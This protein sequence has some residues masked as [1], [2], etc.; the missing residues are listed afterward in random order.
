[1]HESPSLSLSV[2]EARIL[3]ALMEKEKTTPAAYP[4]T[5]NALTT[6]CNQKSARIPIMNLDEGQVA[7]TLRELSNRGLIRIGGLGRAERYSQML[8]RELNINAAQQAVL[9]VLLLR[10]PQ[11]PNEIRISSNRQIEFAE[12]AEVITVLQQLIDH[13]L[14]LVQLIGRAPGQRE[15]RYAQL[16]TGP[17][18]EEQMAQLAATPRTSRLDL[19]EQRLCELEEKVKQ[20]LNT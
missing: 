7:H 18:Q 1:M 2:V 4:L 11:T 14:G 19:L 6:A 17:I 12:P 13:E 3:G 15:D 5:V 10:G 8:S 16:L 9:C 20:L